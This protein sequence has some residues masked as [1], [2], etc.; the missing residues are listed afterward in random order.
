[1]PLKQPEPIG[2]VPGR[3]PVGRAWNRFVS[4][5]TSVRNAVRVIIG[6]Y[7]VSVIAG[8]LLIW[9]LDP[10]DYPDPWLAFWYVL[11]T[12]TTVGYGDA[13]PTEPLGRL[14]GAIVMLL[15]IGFLSILT[16]FITSAFVEA[17]QAARKAP[18]ELAEA[19]YR[20]RMEAKVD[21][22]IARLEALERQG[23]ERSS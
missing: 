3:I 6:A 5:P 9:F 8:G 23:R 22:V 16:A 4:D 21:E 19:A 15:A 2:H 14:V 7:L 17:R 18:I 11:Q 1:L 12:V 13:T 20:T 10:K